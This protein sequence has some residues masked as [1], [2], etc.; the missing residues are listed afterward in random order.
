VPLPTVAAG[1]AGAGSAPVSAPGA[2]FGARFPAG[3]PSHVDCNRLVVRGDVTF[4]ARVTIRGGVE[5]RA[6][7]GPLAIDD[8]AVIAGEGATGSGW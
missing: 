7:D 8:G 2:Y 6:D 5:L 4:G 1:A 3:P